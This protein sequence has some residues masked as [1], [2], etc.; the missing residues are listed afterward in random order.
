MSDKH[1]G[2][3]WHASSAAGFLMTGH[4]RPVCS[5]SWDAPEVIAEPFQRQMDRIFH[6]VGHCAAIHVKWMERTFMREDARLNALADERAAGPFVP[7]TLN[8]L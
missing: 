6:E 7:V 1:Y 5:I 8:D 2:W 4:W 3:H